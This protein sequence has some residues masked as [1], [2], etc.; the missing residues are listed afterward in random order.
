MS[1]SLEPE[2]CRSEQ[3]P[4][5]SLRFHIGV[6]CGSYTGRCRLPG[7]RLSRV[8]LDAIFAL[9]GCSSIH[10]DLSRTETLADTLH[11]P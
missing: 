2:A 3:R 1:S 8:A 5:G 10:A 9:L 4:I 7:R 6:G 11:V